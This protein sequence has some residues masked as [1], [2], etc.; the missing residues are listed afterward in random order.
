MLQKRK[1]ILTG[2]RKNPAPFFALGLLGF[3]VGHL[4]GGSIGAVLGILVG[5]ILAYWL[6][7]QSDSD[8]EP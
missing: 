8:T 1:E 5:V 2:F 3:G 4:L 7:L 6:T